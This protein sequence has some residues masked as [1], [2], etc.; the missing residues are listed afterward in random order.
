MAP[1]FEHI[2]AH[3]PIDI[4]YTIEQTK[5]AMHPDSVQLMIKDMRLSGQN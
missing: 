3:K 4:C 5:H 2:H 1:Y